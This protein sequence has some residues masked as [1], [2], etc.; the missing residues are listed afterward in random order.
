MKIHAI[1]GSSEVGKNMTAL[2]I[3]EDVLLFDCGIFLPA[4][5]K[6]Q[7]KEKVPTERGMRAIGALPDDTYLERLGL[8]E[9]VRAILISHA[10]LDHI[11]AIPY[12]AHKY[13]APLVGTPFTMELIK[14][15]MADNNQHIP[16]KMLKVK[17]NGSFVVKGKSG[18]Y[19]IEFINVPHS[20][21]ETSVIAVHTYEGIF[22]YANEF[23]LDNSPTFGEKANYAKLKELKKKRVDAMMGD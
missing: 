10:H 13:K 2:E 8:K 15:L 16:N 22:L 12:I 23:K 9:K 6:H 17:V 21:L 7:E 19:K 18:D 1:G 5:V 3:G 11:G 4:I 20:T 14:I